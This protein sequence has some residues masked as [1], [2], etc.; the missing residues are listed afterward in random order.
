MGGAIGGVIGGI[1]GSSSASDATN[2]MVNATTQANDLQ[3]REYQ[4]TRKDTAPWRE[5]GKAAVGQLW[6][7]VQAGPGDYKQS[8]GYLFNLA[9]GTGAMNA[10][11]ASTGMLMSGQQQQALNAYGQNYASNDY[12]N[13][14]N[15][16]YQSLTPYQSV[17]GLGQTAVGQTN[18]TGMNAANNMSQ[19]TLYAGQARASGYMAQNSI[20]QQGLGNLY[21]S[22]SNGGMGGLSSLFSG[23]SGSGLNNYSGNP[24]VTF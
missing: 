11:A 23:S 19:N 21:N 16:Y 5:A 7:K 22:A 1:F 13:F 8:P 4:Q 14:L 15:R 12:S 10:Q 17:A 6:N 20:M 24:Y 3:W 9:Q 18:Q 2:A